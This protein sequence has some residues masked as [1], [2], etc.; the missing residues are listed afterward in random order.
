MHERCTTLP[1]KAAAVA[2]TAKARTAAFIA[3]G[4]LDGSARGQTRGS[5][6][7]GWPAWLL[8]LPKLQFYNL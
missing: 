5:R 7:L 4:W 6:T 3:P 8:L 1:G 2:R